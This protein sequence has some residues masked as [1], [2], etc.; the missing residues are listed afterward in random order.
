MLK[1]GAD[2]QAGTVLESE[3]VDGDPTGFAVPY[4]GA[5]TAVILCR[6]VDATDAAPLVGVEAAVIDSDEVKRFWLSVYEK[7]RGV[8]KIDPETDAEKR[9][10]DRATAAVAKMGER[11]DAEKGIAGTTAW[12]AMNA[13]TGWLQHD[14]GTIKDADRRAAAVLIGEAGDRSADALDYAVKTLL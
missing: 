4:V 1:A 12:N 13:Y 9:A 10:L 8:I 3:E 14:R 7:Q 5:E 2:Y 11:F 6:H